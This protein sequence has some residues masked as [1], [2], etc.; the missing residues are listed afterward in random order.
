MRHVRLLFC[1]MGALV[2]LYAIHVE[3]MKELDED[4]TAS[5]DISDKMSCS[6]VLTSEYGHIF[7]YI[8]LFPK[9]SVL[10]QSN[11]FF[12]LLFY[13]MV[14]F[15]SLSSERTAFVKRISFF[16]GITGLGMSL[17]LG[18]ILSFILF[19][20]CLVCVSSYVCNTVIFIDTAREFFDRKL[21]SSTS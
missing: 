7:S 15:L 17:I 18:Y 20:I 21:H 11:A 9:N 5:C 1:G 16:L 10:D 19:D 2:S 13:I 12:G 6:R 3:H 14:A 8:G 4:F